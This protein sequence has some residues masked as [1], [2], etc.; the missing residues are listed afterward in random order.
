VEVATV[1]YTLYVVVLGWN[2]K[3]KRDWFYVLLTLMLLLPPTHNTLRKYG[4]IYY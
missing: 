1:V 3:Q 4:W 2:L